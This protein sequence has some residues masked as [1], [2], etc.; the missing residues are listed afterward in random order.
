MDKVF[1]EPAR[2]GLTQG[3]NNLSHTS[4][5]MR[6]RRQEEAVRGRDGSTRCSRKG[7]EGLNPEHSGASLTCRHQ[8]TC[9]TSGGRKSH[10]E[11]GWTPGRGS[12]RLCSSGGESLGTD[13]S[14]DRQEKGEKLLLTW[15]CRGKMNLGQ[16]RSIK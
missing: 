11:Q 7:R 15:R 3:R 16:G 2:L 13:K 6:S 1:P 8:P 10:L 14:I 9:S 12:H 4:P 5:D